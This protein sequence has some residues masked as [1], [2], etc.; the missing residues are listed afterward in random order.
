MASSD[1]F[2]KIRVENNYWNSILFHTPIAFFTALKFS[3]SFS[4]CKTVKMGF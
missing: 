1:A 4:G 3:M 2:F